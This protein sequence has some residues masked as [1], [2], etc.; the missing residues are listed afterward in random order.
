MAT[1]NDVVSAGLKSIIVLGA[2]SA[3]D[4]ADAQDFIS[5][6][7]YYMFDLDARGVKLGYTEV[8]SLGDEITIPSGALRGLIANV[9]IEVAPEYGGNISPAL[10]QRAKDGL[11][12]MRRLGISLGKTALPSNLPIGS[13]NEGEY[14]Y[15]DS[16]YYPDQEEDILAEASGTPYA[17]LSM[18]GNTTATTITTAGTSLLV[19][20]TWV[21]DR[22]RE[23][24]G[25]A[26]GRITYS[27]EKDIIL[28]IAST[29]TVEPATAS[30]Q[31]ISAYIALNGVE[32]AASRRQ[33]EATA[34]LPITI[35][36]EYRMKL[37]KDDYIELFIA[38]DTSTDNL[39][40]SAATFKVR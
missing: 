33:T 31:I 15:A 24:A 28:D 4:S 1:A 13:G 34:S 3:L 7:N 30:S 20:G 26:A 11:K 37:E 10:I 14:H 17:S 6:M 36:F 18:T 8:S 40:V 9:A 39:L 35:P 25:T 12:A 27:S 22:A 5:A 19:A 21:I 23:V 38:N 2:E 32:V 16:Y 29:I